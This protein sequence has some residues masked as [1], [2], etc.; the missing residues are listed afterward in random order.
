MMETIYTKLESASSTTKS[1][2][3]TFGNNMQTAS[4]SMGGVSSSTPVRME[5]D[6]FTA[7]DAKAIRV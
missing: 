6:F 7:H 4:G 2:P 1:T 5:R 3:S